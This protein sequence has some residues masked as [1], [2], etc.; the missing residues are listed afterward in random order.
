MIRAAARPTHLLGAAVVL[1]A[2]GWALAAAGLVQ[3]RPCLPG[4]ATLGGAHLVL[5][6]PSSACPSGVALDGAAMLGV[7]ASVG[8]GVLIVQVLGAGA[9][10]AAGGVLTR[11]RAVVR[12]I[13][14]RVVPGISQPEP[15]TV[16]A[17]TRPP[18]VVVG[19]PARP[20]RGLAARVGLRA[21]P[22]AA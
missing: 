1:L 9:L 22:V 12:A 11:M 8:V 17:L 10:S 2:T 21:P 5:L 14:D 16:V 19:V 7:I 6:H 15:V 3:V 4:E 20:R 13:L 18:G